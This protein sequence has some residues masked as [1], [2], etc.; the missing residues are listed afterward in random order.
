MGPCDTIEQEWSVKIRSIIV[1]ETAL[2]WLPLHSLICVINNL[3][4]A[5]E[6]SLLIT[7][8]ICAP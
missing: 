3:P 5:A 6:S 8:Y 2:T 1:N 7:I 4:S